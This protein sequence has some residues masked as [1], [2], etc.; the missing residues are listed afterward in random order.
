MFESALAGIKVLE[1]C[2]MVAG[3]YCAKLLA[4]LG[5]EVVKIEKPGHG[6]EARKRPPFPNDVPDAETSGLFLYLNTN[7]LSI[8]L[9]VETETG[10]QIFKELVRGAD[11]LVEDNAPG[12]MKKQGL[13]YEVLKELNSKLIMVSIT[14]FGQT[15][16]YR[17]HKAYPLNVFQAGGEGYLTPSGVEN[18]GRPP[19]KVG[20]FLEEYDSG[21]NAAIAV[22]AALYWRTSSGRG[23]FIDISKQESLISLNR[24]DVIVRYANE[25]KL[26]T[27]AQQGV[28]YGGIL[29]CK[30]GD[31][32]VFVTWEERQWD[33][34]VSMMGNPEWARDEKFKD[35]GARFKH[36]ELINALLME[37]LVN[38]SKEELYHMGQAHGVP[39]G[40]V[41]SV[42]DL[43]NS[44]HLRARGFF[45]EIEHPKAGRL[46]YPSAPYKFLLT[47]WRV[48]RPAPLLGEHN[49][50]VYCKR[51][52]Y[53][54]N[55]LVK[56]RE[57]GII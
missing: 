23:Q 17:D 10:R 4:D 49:E 53:E 22:V 36:G 27:R 28:P 18:V 39:F 8:T 34:L 16:S 42:E 35:H 31:Y 15:G 2:Q 3:P 25:R 20:S 1:Y 5:A 37:W 43:V 21:L 11:V 55:Q 38:F 12:V 56:L 46:R 51:L 50:E 14:P 19:L 48:S 45:V 40:M 44:E 52:G 32:T 6:D 13:D 24:M 30:G 47:P 33:R 26:L 7:K 9:S 41:S 29:P 54:K 57:A